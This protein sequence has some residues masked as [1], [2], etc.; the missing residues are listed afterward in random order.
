MKIQYSI[1]FLILGWTAFSQDPTQKNK[2]LVKTEAQKNIELAQK[3]PIDLYTVISIQNDS[4]YIDTTLTIQKEYKFNYLRKDLFGLLPFSNDGQTYNSLQYLSKNQTAY[5]DFGFQA[6]QFNYLK[7]NDINYYSVP[8]PLT[9]LYYKTV[10]QQGQNLDS[11]IT[12]NT[13]PQ[14]NFS[15]AYKGLRS[16]GNYL[17]QLSS[18]G[19]FRATAS[20]NSKKQNYTIKTHFTSQDISNQENGGIVNTADFENGD[21]KF[22]D[23]ARLQ[24][25]LTD[26]KSLLEGKRFFAFQSLRLNTKNQ[27]NN[28]FLN[29]KFT[30]ENKYFVFTQPTVTS[31]ITTQSGATTYLNRFGSS[32]VSSGINDKTSYQ[33]L[34][35]NAGLSFENDDLGKIYFGLSDF[36]YHYFYNNV[37]VVN[38]V[39]I[40]NAINDHISSFETQYKFQKNNW[41]AVFEYSNSITKQD[42]SDLDLKLEYAFDDENQITIGFQ[43]TNK[44]PNHVFNL[45]QSAYTNYNWKNDFKNEKTDHFQVA[46]TTK[47]LDASIEWSRLQDRLYF[48]NTS[49]TALITLPKQFEAAINLAAVKIEKDFS[50]RKF[51]LANT[52]LYQ[53]VAQSERILNLP[54]LVLRHTLYYS[55]VLFNKAMDLQT[56]FT[57]QYF[58]Q[59]AANEYNPLLGEFFVQSEVE[60]G[61]FPVVDFF[62]NAKIKQT[63]IYLKAEHF[64]AAFSK[65]NYFASPSNPLVDFTIRFGL[66]WNFFQ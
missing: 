58:S 11:F 13:S 35:H 51:S 27:K 20:Y 28:L 57:V 31:Q 15:I 49:T 50:F 5:P 10:I 26:A 4:T 7:T 65:S 29:Y 54:K 66:V 21:N 1:L 3:A 6:K 43:K 53:K 32:Y 55:D 12:M 33:N 63:R 16:L 14:F 46:A 36:K 44:L 25:Y 9:E 59:Y 48:E 34:I 37:L 41:N 52:V 19:N 8:T 24:V 2:S 23:R 18:T 47:W 62:V 22:S 64:N 61:N 17:N 39:T 30:A 56:G 42:L 40:P 60:I 45:F 38:G